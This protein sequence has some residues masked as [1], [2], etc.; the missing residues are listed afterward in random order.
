MSDVSS[1]R[2]NLDEPRY[3]QNTYAGRAKHF[4]TTTNPLNLFTRPSELEKA[5]ELVESYK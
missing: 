5:K 2:I 1:H 3:D 4:F